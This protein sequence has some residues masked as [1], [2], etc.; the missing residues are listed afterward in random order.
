MWIAVVQCMAMRIVRPV[1]RIDLAVRILVGSTLVLAGLAKLFA[2]QATANVIE[3][4]GIPDGLALGIIAG[5]CETCVGALILLGWFAQRIAFASL[6]F[7][8]PIAF[9][10]HYPF[11]ER[12]VD[13][14]FDVLVIVS[15]WIVATRR[16]TS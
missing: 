6:L 7:Y 4:H 12:A 9:F 10:F 2:P 8:V 14:A 15:L 11:W 3:A 16:S 1:V 13:T 5:V